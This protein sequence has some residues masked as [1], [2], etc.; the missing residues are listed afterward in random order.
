MKISTDLRIC[1]DVA[2]TEAGRRRH[3]FC[4]V[5][6]LVFALLN[7]DDARRVLQRSGANLKALQRGLEEHL[8][9]NVESVPEDSQLTVHPSLGFSRVVQRAWLHCQGAGKDEVL[10]KNVLVAIFAESDSHAVHLLETSGVTRLDLV[11]FLSHG[12]E[13]SPGRR[14]PAFEEGREPAGEGEG[15]RYDRTI[16]IS[17]III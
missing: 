11:R 16:S 5:E 15:A 7:D 14:R 10:P 13:K 3:E 8:S 4:T 17:V 1:I 6:H 12:V 2:M 9:E